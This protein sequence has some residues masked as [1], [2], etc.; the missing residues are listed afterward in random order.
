MEHPSASAVPAKALV[1]NTGYRRYSACITAHAHTHRPFSLAAEHLLYHLWSGTRPLRLQRRHRGDVERDFFSYEQRPRLAA[2][3][4]R[5][6]VR[7]ER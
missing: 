5:R 3:S 7:F 1:D 2:V 6:H 4:L